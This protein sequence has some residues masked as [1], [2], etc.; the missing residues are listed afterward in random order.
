MFEDLFFACFENAWNFA[1]NLQVFLYKDLVF[2]NT[3]SLCPWPRAY[4]F[5]ASRRSVLGISVL[6]LGFFCVLV[7]STP[8]LQITI[9][10]HQYNAFAIIRIVHHLTGISYC[11]IIRPMDHSIYAET[12]GRG[13]SEEFEQYVLKFS[14][15]FG[16]VSS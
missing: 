12:T 11:T 14:L 16:I 13:N 3:C 6:G 15:R 4:L 5:L 1:E 10:N 2:E 9:V 8:L 7:S